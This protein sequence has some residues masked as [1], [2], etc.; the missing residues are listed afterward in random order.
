MGKI[1]LTTFIS[2]D[3]V[4][5]SPGGP[6]E[7]PSNGFAL[8]G[9]GVPFTRDPVFGERMD[10][11]FARCDALLLGRATYDTFK[12]FWPQ[13]ENDA[14]GAARTI[15]TGIKY[16]VST[17]ATD[18]SW[19]ETRIIR[20][21]L[22]EIDAIKSRHAGEIQIH[23][24]AGLARSLLET[25]AIDEMN[26]FVFPVVLGRGKRLFGDA[27]APAA[28]ER[29][30]SVTGGGGLVMCRYRRSGPVVQ[31]TATLEMEG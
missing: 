29:I 23:G 24:S 9:W 8:G 2:I 4:M 10:A 1:T 16:L 14:N 21:P 7:D 19:Q 12:A 18:N 30:D 25:D 13:V 26:L 27:S 3:G 6:D 17:T 5:Q 28:F 22:A 11:I 31:E 20:D 15:N